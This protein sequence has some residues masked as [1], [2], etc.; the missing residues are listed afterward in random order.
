MTINQIVYNLR[1][2]IRDAKHDDYKI[3]NRQIEFIVNYVRAKLIRQDISKGRSIS[4]NIIQDLGNVKLIEV[5]KTNSSFAIGS[6]ILRTELKI[7]KPL[8][9]EYNDAF[10]YIGGLDK[11]SPFQVSTKAF[12]DW[13]KYSKFGNKN[14]F[15]YYYDGY[16]FIKNCDL[17]LEYINISGVFENPREI[18][19]FK[20]TDGSSCYNANVENYPISGNMLHDLSK[21]IMKESLYLVLTLPEDIVNDANSE[22]KK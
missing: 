1:N 22:I 16:V 5:D 21:I 20:N 2:L 14:I 8:E 6:S 4:G 3:S 7:P 15:A 12:S 17:N 19:K 9:L 18:N 10:T 13:Q 11:A